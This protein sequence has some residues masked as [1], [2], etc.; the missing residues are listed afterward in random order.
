MV[1]A[2]TMA[3]MPIVNTARLEYAATEGDVQFTVFDTQGCQ[4]MAI[5]SINVNA[6]NLALAATPSI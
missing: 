2:F 6:A 4:V 5:P 3:P 1:Q